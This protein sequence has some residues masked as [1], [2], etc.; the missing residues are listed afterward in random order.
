MLSV[1]YPKSIRDRLFGIEGKKENELKSEPTTKRKQMKED[2]I[3]ASRYQLKNFMKSSPSGHGDSLGG[4][5]SKP[6]ADLFLNA[7][8]IFADIAGFT[9]WSSVREPAQ[10]FTLL[11]TVYRAFDTIA[12]RKKVFKVETVG[13]CYV[14]VTGLPGKCD[15]WFNN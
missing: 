6:I 9:A 7:T 3:K 2:I 5:G 14:A 8:V 11:E 4:F 10:V 13:D 1:L 15:L 12:K